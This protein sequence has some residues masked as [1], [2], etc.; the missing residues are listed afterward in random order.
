MPQE[1]E[2]LAAAFMKMMA[3]AVEELSSNT[4]VAKA[5]FFTH[6]LDRLLAV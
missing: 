5:A 1:A 6:R 4:K 2:V 3:E